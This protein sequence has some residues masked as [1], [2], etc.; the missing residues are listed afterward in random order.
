VKETD[1]RFRFIAA[2]MPSVPSPAFNI[3]LVT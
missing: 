1:E 2:I 3:R